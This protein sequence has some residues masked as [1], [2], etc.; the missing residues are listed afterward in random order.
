ME[1]HPQEEP[2]RAGSPLDVEQA[3]MLTAQIREAITAVQQAGAVLAERVR[4]AHESRIWRPL[5]YSSWAEYAAA[6][7][8]ISRAQA[9]RLIDIAT[10]AGKLL[11][12]ATTM[13]GLS[14]AGDTLVLSGRA[15]RD[16]RDRVD[17]VAA[18]LARLIGQARAAGE[19]SGDD[20]GDLLRRAVAEVRA[21]PPPPVPPPVPPLAAPGAPSRIHE[22]RR[23][24]EELYAAAAELGLICLEIAPGYMPDAEAA[25]ALERYAEEVGLDLD[26][27]LAHRRYA[28]T[29]DRRCLRDIL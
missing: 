27:V 12:A 6:E 22:G 9:Y 4:R 26:G 25:R 1:R 21:A 17:Q 28:L 5:G 20:V 16:V 2:D 19:L 14:S 29:G 15:L 13:A 11:E 8:G 3:R 24:V 18:V 10:T 7:F 23:M